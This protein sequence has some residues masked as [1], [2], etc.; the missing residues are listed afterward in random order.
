M[1]QELVAALIK[2]TPKGSDDNGTP[3]YTE[4]R[5]ELFAEIVGTKRSEFYAGLSAGMRPE[6][7]VKIYEFEYD[8]EKIIELDG[9]RYQIVRTYPVED[10]RLELICSDIA[11]AG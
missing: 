8:N 1:T 5:R 3:V 9:K 6:K 11:E 4:N 7:T 10:E 2:R